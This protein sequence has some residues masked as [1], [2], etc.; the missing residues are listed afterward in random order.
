MSEGDTNFS[1]ILE[2]IKNKQ[3]PLLL[4]LR[5]KYHKQDKA[6]QDWAYKELVYDLYCEA[7]P[8]SY[9]EVATVMGHSKNIDKLFQSCNNMAEANLEKKTEGAIQEKIY[10]KECLSCQISRRKEMEMQQTQSKTCNNK[11]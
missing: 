3:V 10:Q 1:E 9:K 4:S 11:S 7:I 5:E 8:E 6:V 2:R